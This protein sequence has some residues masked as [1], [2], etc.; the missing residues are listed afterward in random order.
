MQKSKNKYCAPIK[1]SMEGTACYAP[2][3]VDSSQSQIRHY[4]MSASDVLN[5]TSYQLCIIPI[6][7]GRH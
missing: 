5:P 6:L 7:C 4:L 3:L 2:T 1:C